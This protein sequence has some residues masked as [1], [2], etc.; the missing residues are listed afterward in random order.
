MK[1]AGSSSLLLT[2]AALAAGL[3]LAGDDEPAMPK[4]VTRAMRE[5]L[6][7]IYREE[8]AGYTIYRDA[9][10]QEK[11]ELR[12]DPVYVWTNPLRGRVQDGAVFVWTCRGRSEAI[13]TIFTSQAAGPRF[14]THEFHSLAITALDVT[15][16][17]EENDTEHQWKPSAPG[18]TLVPIAGAPAPAPSPVRRLTQMRALANEFSARIEDRKGQRW[19]LRL[20]PHPLYRYQSTD[21]E[22]LDGAVFSFVTSEGTDPEVLLVLEARRKTGGTDTSWQYALARFSLLKLWVWHKGHEVFTAQVIPYN[23]P[24]QDSHDR[25]R[26]FRHRE[27]PD[28]EEPSP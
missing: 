22:V 15:H 6:L 9:G 27:L 24:H 12:S 5:R 14:L 28:I 23:L 1:R 20:L 4:P 2:A 7:E 3:A 26:C 18:I 13:G 19:E 17:G 21:P 8:A 11:V 16:Q 10:R 25:Y